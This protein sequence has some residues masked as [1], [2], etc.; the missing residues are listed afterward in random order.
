MARLIL[1]V[2]AGSSSLKISVFRLVSP[3]QLQSADT[4][5]SHVVL[6]AS[7]SITSIF[8]S[9]KFSF[10]LSDH[11]S[12]RH[13]KKGDAQGIRDHATAFAYL[14]DNLKDGANIDA[15]DILY[16]CHRVVHG[17]DFHEPVVI[18]KETY[19]HIERLSDLAPLYALFGN[20]S[21]SHHPDLANLVTTAPRSLLWKRACQ[22]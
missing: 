10:N 15:A 18:N 20:W 6:I 21:L 22:I 5:D 1:A 17:G 2:N 7:C 19:H 16:V 12:P 8:S 4:A 11:S 9:P 14:L 13:T 3:Q